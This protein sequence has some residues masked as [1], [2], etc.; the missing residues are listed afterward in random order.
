ML[1]LM[2]C[3]ARILSVFAVLVWAL[4]MSLTS[5]VSLASPQLLP[6]PPPLH[7]AAS[8]QPGG[9]AGSPVAT[10]GEAAEF[11]VEYT[12][13]KGLKEKVRNIHILYSCVVMHIQC[14][15]NNAH[16]TINN[17]WTDI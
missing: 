2:D 15:G 3:D 8:S 5:H 9:V 10:G 17:T 6:P 1:S 16:F 12:T 7:E 13:S 11:V 14:G 4:G